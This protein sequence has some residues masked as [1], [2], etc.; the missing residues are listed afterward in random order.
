MK[1]SVKCGGIESLILTAALMAVP[2]LQVGPEI[3]HNK[4]RKPA[5]RSHDAERIKAA[6]EKRQKLRQ[7]SISSSLSLFIFFCP[8]NAPIKRFESGNCARSHVPGNGD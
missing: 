3:A 7:S 8:Y 6:Q 5:Q 4:Q 1:A 2:G